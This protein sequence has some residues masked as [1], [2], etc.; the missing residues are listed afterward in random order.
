MPDAAALD[1]APIAKLR[2]EACGAAAC[3]DGLSCLAI[4]GGYC[5]SPCTACGSGGSCT[6]TWR[7]G[8]LCLASC[9]TTADCR[10]AEGYL[11]D[12]TWKTC[13]LPNMGTIV[14]RS[15]PGGGNRDPKF[16]AVEALGIGSEP[17]A[18]ASDDGGLTIAVASRDGDRASI[19]LDRL[20]PP[21]GAPRPTTA[22]PAGAPPVVGAPAMPGA[23]A[24]PAAPLTTTLADA[25]AEA[26]LARAGA[27]LDAVW[28]ADQAID[29]ATSTDRGA[30]WSAPIA[31]N[32]PLDADADRP[33][34]LAGSDARHQPIT[35][36]LYASGAGLRVRATRD[37]GKTFSRAVTPLPGS[38]G[39]ATIGANGWLHVVA[40][41]GGPLGAFGS[42]DAQIAYA[43]SADG[44]ASFTRPQVLSKRD[45]MLPYFFANPSIAV[46]DRRGW[47]YIAYTR[48]GRDA[49]WDLVISASKDKGVTWHRT[50]IGDDPACAIHMVPN[51]ALDPTTGTLHVAWYDSRG[52]GRFAHAVCPPG[53]ATCTQLGAISDTPFALSTALDVSSVGE[54]ESLVIDDKRRTLHA[55]WTQPV[56]GV[57]HVFHA[58]AK[59]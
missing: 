42:A 35:Y 36:V 40:L 24:P 1:A 10:A 46:D 4:A 15:C 48:G 8:A 52:G 25:G 5:A 44:G 21:I 38:H 29:L 45:E 22:R 3:A 28:R 18:I 14:P 54:H 34:V 58:A 17:S 57:A 59:L 32:D 30:T 55:V 43:V 39:N 50:R 2:G 19:H 51:L 11:C 27:N 20:A 31:V 12:P 33:M 23:G 13:M 47:I 16:G 6:E 56:D 26:W 41:S 49:V 7:A 53:A 9:T 37:Q